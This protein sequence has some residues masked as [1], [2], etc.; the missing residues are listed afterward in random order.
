MFEN[1]VVLF[2]SKIK[3]RQWPAYNLLAQRMKSAIEDH[4]GGMTAAQI[5][6]KYHNKEP[7]KRVPRNAVHSRILTRQA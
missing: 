5:K 3:R 1:T 6:E 7:P 2:Y 4:E